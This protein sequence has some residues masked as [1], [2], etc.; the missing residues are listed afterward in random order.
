VRFRGFASKLTLAALCVAAVLAFAECGMRVAGVGEVMTFRP[1]A[2]FGYLMQPSQRIST[3][4]IPVEINALGLRGPA[5]LDPKPAEVT[6]VLFLGDSITYGGGR[7]PEAELFCRRIEELARHDGLRVESVN[8]SAPGWS[9]QNWAAWIAANG[10]LGADLVVAV[11][12]TIDLARPFA[13]WDQY[14]LVEHAPRLR[15]TTLWLRLAALRAAAAP[16][17]GDAPAANLRAVRELAARLAP[18][19]LVAVLVPSRAPDSEPALWTPYLELFPDAV[20]L[21]AALVPSDFL[22]DVHLSS[23][24]HRAVAEGIYAG[25]AP[26]LA[27]LAAVRGPRALQLHALPPPDQ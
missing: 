12:P 10:T 1:D 15:L 2:R 5:P 21:R 4:G 7:I 24:G 14:N 13:T 27:Q 16:Q 3:Y 22:D 8:L 18:T 19:P 20:D 6:R 9:P 26:R 17:S 25:L 23:A 11:I